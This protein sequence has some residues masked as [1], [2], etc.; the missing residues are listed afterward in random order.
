MC[1]RDRNGLCN[2]RI[3]TRANFPDAANIFTASFSMGVHTILH[4]I[5]I[6]FGMAIE[7]NNDLAPRRFDAT[8][9]P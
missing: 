1:S 8:I 6:W 2:P 3:R 7:A 9:H 5:G 4:V